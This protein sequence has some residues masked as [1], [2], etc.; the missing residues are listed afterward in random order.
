MSKCNNS[1]WLCQCPCPSPCCNCVWCISISMLHVNV[2]PALYNVHLACRCPWCIFLGP[3]CMSRMSNSC[4]MSMA[5]LQVFVHAACPCPCSM[6][7][8]I[9]HV[10]VHAACKRLCCVSIFMLLVYFHAACPFYA[11]WPCLWWMS[12]FNMCPCPR[13]MHMS[14]LHIHVYAECLCP[15]CMSGSMLHIHRGAFSLLG[16]TA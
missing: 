6:S 1:L 11:A 12:M 3:C 16:S 4:C 13:C 7:M 9:L 5:I 14:M 15:C 2:H 10:H 8:P